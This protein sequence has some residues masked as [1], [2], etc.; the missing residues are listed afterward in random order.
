MTE[1]GHNGT[2]NIHL[3][4][5]IWTKEDAKKIRKQWKNGFV[6][7]GNQNS[8]GQITNYVN[9]KTV[10][11]IIK[12]I[13]KIDEQHKAYQPKIL[14]SKGIGDNLRTMH[15]QPTNHALPP[16]TNNLRTRS[17]ESK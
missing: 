8:Y 6:W 4:G 10:N 14:C 3:H 16:Y 11:Y 7:L 13:T 17:P 2:E 1:L 5:I 12:Y 9:S 15:Q